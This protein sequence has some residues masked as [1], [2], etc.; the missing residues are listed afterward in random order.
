MVEFDLDSS[1]WNRVDITCVVCLRLPSVIAEAGGYTES[2]PF[3]YCDSRCYYCEECYNDVVENQREA[4]AARLAK[5]RRKKEENAKEESNQTTSQTTNA[6]A[7]ATAKET[8]ENDGVQVDDTDGNEQE[9]K[10]T[11]NNNN[12]GSFVNNNNNSNSNNNSS[13]NSN[14]NNNNNFRNN[15]ILWSELESMK[16]QQIEVQNA[17][18]NIQALLIDDTYLAGEKSK[19]EKEIQL[20]EHWKITGI[21]RKKNQLKAKTSSV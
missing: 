20:K 2:L 11:Q 15:E 1:H 18:K 13:S 6:T 19:K 3:A 21:G 8:I 5:K 4:K 7:N 17:L 10:Q 12:T 14:S 16:N 9:Q